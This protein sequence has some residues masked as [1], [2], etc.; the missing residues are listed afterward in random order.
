MNR[1][2]VRV[3]LN[4]QECTLF[5]I[6]KMLTGLYPMR[7]Q[8]HSEMPIYLFHLLECPNT[9]LPA[10]FKSE[11]YCSFNVARMFF[12]GLTSSI[13]HDKY[14]FRGDIDL[15]VPLSVH[16]SLFFVYARTGTWKETVL[17]SSPKL[18]CNDCS[19]TDLGPAST[20]WGTFRLGFILNFLQMTR[21]ATQ[22]EFYRPRSSSRRSICKSKLNLLRMNQF[23]EASV[24]SPVT[25]P[26]A[27]LFGDTDT[28]GGEL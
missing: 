13:L 7:F 1:F 8:Q 21:M 4:D 22:N 28:D 19:I 14:S 12:R 18:P 11:R 25:E 17:K 27:S 5:R 10:G 2:C 15:C 20:L 24:V 6:K 3:C 26:R 9:I 16:L 23:S